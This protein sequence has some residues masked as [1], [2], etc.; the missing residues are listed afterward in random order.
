MALPQEA[1]VQ[2]MHGFSASGLQAEFK[3][4]LQLANRGG[5]QGGLE[6]FMDDG[7]I[8]VVGMVERARKHNSDRPVGSDAQQLDV[9][10][11]EGPERLRGR[12][13]RQVRQQCATVCDKPD[14]EY[15]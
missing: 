13:I 8:R 12:L 10:L 14:R 6:L 11:K 7:L 3:I 9:G 5:G 1:L 2:A 4:R 15:G